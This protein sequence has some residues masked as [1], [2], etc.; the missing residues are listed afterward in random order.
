ML[1]T[2]APDRTENFRMGAADLLAPV[3]GAINR[4]IQAASAYVQEVSGLTRP[5][6]R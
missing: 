6:G 5:A 2:F 3:I 4:P 1:S